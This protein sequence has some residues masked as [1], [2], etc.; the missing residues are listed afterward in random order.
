M[1]KLMQVPIVVGALVFGSGSIAANAVTPNDY[2]DISP[3]VGLAA[4]LASLSENEDPQSGS[5]EAS[6]VIDEFQTNEVLGAD[7]SEPLAADSAS[8]DPEVGAD[9]AGDLVELSLLNIND[10]HGRISGTLM[11]GVLTASPTVQFAGT[12]ERLRAEHGAANTLFMSAG[13][14]LGASLFPSAIAQDAPTIDVLNALGLEVSAVGNHEF[15]GGLADLRRIEGLLDA[16]IL[17][18]NVYYTATGELALPAYAIVE[19]AGLRVGVVGVAPEDTAFLVGADLTML[20]FGDPVEAVNRTVLEMEALPEAE[21][22]DIYVAQYHEG[23]D[24]GRASSTIEEQMRRDPDFAAIVEDTSPQVDV[25]FNAHTHQE[26]DWD[27]LVPG[28]TDQTRPI[29]QTGQYGANIGNVVLT[30]DPTT[31]DVTAYETTLVPTNT[32][33]MA[34]LVA[35][36][37]TQLNPIVSIVTDALVAA[38]VEGSIPVGQLTAPLTRAYTGGEYVDGEFAL[39]PDSLENRQQES[40]MGTAV[41][42]AL[43]DATAQYG[44]PADFGLGNS[45]G[46]RADLYPAEDGTVT[47]AQVRAVLPFNGEVSNVKLT[48]SQIKALLEQQW[49]GTF[50][51]LGISDNFSYTYTEVSDPAGGPDPVGYIWGMT[52]NGQ[53]VEMDRVYTVATYKFLAQGGDGF[54]EFLNGQALHTGIP[55]WQAWVDYLRDSSPLSPDFARRAV[56]VD[57]P[58]GS[59]WTPGDTV[60]LQYSNLNMPAVG[61]PAN[62]SAQVALGESPLGEFPVSEGAATVSFTVP[63]SEPGARDLQFMATPSQTSAVNMVDVAASPGEPGGGDPEPEKPGTQTPDGGTTGGSAGGKLPVTGASVFGVL[64]A[65]GLLGGAGIGLRRLRVKA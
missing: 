39:T 57:G 58:L 54:T 40:P 5:G 64:I 2:S 63:A 32:V 61:A 38:D 29:V 9:A 20:E 7:T 55:D 28:T 52:L 59:A 48:G 34:D 15:D 49:D 11:G 21:R 33:P 37:P 19:A 3:T 41:S 53:P 6:V 56:R 35:A 13:D 24:A 27:G 44:E 4:E 45:G 26:Y 46:L 65:A 60:S 1:R 36:Y 16:P 62:T 42:N 43:R 25:I 23:A 10:F 22:P 12:V 18:A 50:K 17:G 14:N 30:V 47:I 8:T 31:N 51:Q